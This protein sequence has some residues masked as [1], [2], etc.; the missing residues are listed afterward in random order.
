[1]KRLY[2]ITGAGGHLA[3]TI[4]KYL[5]R[6]LNAIIVHPSA[7]L[8]PYDDGNN[9]MTQYHTLKQKNVVNKDDIK[10]EN[11]NV[12]LKEVGQMLTLSNNAWSL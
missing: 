9:H 2:I 7:I 10:V 3:S 1:M 6:G 8:G 5:K 11:G 12:T 4:I